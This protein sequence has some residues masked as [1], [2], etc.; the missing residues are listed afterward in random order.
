MMPSAAAV[1]GNG[2]RQRPCTRGGD[3]SMLSVAVS[4]SIG[5]YVSPKANYLEEQ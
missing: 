2:S 3:W 1:R 5:D 4:W